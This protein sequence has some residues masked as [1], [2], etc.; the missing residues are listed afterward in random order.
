MPEPTKPPCE[1]GP[2][3]KLGSIGV[4]GELHVEVETDWVQATLNDPYSGSQ[5]DLSATA[6]QFQMCLLPLPHLRVLRFAHAF[7]S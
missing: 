5:V 2:K 4:L 3:V 6:L 1:H 7:R